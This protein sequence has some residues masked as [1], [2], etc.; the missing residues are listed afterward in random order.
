MSSY[1]HYYSRTL[2]ENLSEAY[3]SQWTYLQTKR[4]YLLKNTLEDGTELEI[5]FNNITGM[6][7][8]EYIRTLAEIDS[9]FHKLGY[10]LKY[11]V[12]Q[13]EIFDDT[14]KLNSF[15]LICMLIVFL[16]DVCKPPVLPRIIHKNPEMDNTSK[17]Y[18]IWMSKFNHGNVEIKCPIYKKD[19]EEFQAF[20]NEIPSKF[21]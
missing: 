17:F 11:F 15:S 13:K 21:P 4:L 18:R 20:E 1:P 16:Q 8:S 5:S 7:N 19:N 10:Y 3:G 14:K 2:R 6:L 12:K 9:R